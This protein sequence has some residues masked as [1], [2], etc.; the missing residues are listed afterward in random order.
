MSIAKCSSCLHIA[1]FPSLLHL[2]HKLP[3]PKQVLSCHLEKSEFDHRIIWRLRFIVVLKN[4]KVEKRLWF[5]S[6]NSF[7]KSLFTNNIA[8]YINIDNRKCAIYFANFKPI[9]KVLKQLIIRKDIS[10]P[11][12]FSIFRAAMNPQAM[13]LLHHEKDN[14]LRIL[15]HPR[16]YPN[17]VCV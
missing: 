10:Y 12:F 13:F 2:H 4:R 14:L 5:Y 6:I 17:P 8:F 9:I 3:Q 7:N 15:Y 1:A 11:E 16:P